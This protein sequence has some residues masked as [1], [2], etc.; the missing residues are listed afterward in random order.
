MKVLAIGLN[1]HTAPLEVREKLAF[2][3]EELHQALLGLHQVHGEGVIISTCNRTEVYTLAGDTAHGQ[4][5]VLQF[6]LETRGLSEEEMSPYLFVLEHLEAVRHLYQVASG[7]DSMILGEAQVLG[8]V[9]D[10]Y[11]A[12]VAAGVARGL[13]SKLFHQALRV[14]KRARRETAIGRN[15]LS[16]SY[17]CVE[18][19][20]RTLGEVRGRSVLVV[21]VGDAGKLVAQAL[22]NSGA[23]EVLVTNRTYGRAQELAQELGGRALPF[24][25][26]PQALEQVDVMISSTGSPGYVISR[27]MVQ[28]A[29]AARL[30]GLLFLID[31]AVPRDIDP[32][33]GELPGVHLY[34]ID[35]LD[36]VSEA[37]RLERWREAQRVEVIVQEEV[38]RFARWWE[39]LEAMPTVVTL[40]QQAEALRQAEMEKVLRHLPHL[41]DQER[42]RIEAMSRALVKKLLHHPTTSLK[43]VRD[44]QQQQLAQELFA[45]LRQDTPEL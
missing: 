19:A 22:Q 1:H 35:D 10:A 11:G 36:A 15:A 25:E 38:E 13:L 43:E 6:L 2:T 21:G 31:I 41:T 9:R 17:A 27:E 7:L 37:N 23:G 29:V 12:A 34:D 20:R 8:Q 30:D 5:A 24:E 33:V 14:G 26:L 18:L 16:V 44:P 32:A 28:Q 3:K 45:L 42:W 40:R 4:R 39:S